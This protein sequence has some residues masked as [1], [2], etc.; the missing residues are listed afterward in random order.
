M[1]ETWTAEGLPISLLQRGLQ[2]EEL[3][4]RTIIIII[5]VQIYIYLSSPLPL[6]TVNGDYY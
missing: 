5:M 2:T 3:I 4:L 1:L 6:E